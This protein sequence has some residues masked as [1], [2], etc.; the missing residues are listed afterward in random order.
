[1]TR[2]PA[3]LA[4]AGALFLAAPASAQSL[5]EAI[6]AAIANS[7][8]LEAA[9]ARQDAA[10]A[11]VRQ[12]QAERNPSASVQGQ[13]GYGRI[14]PRGFFGLTADNVTPRVAQVGAEWPLFTGGRISAA[15]DQARAGQAMAAIGSDAALLDLRLQ[16][17]AAYS[18]ALASRREVESYGAVI[19]MLEEVLR[20]S[21]LM[22]EAGAATSTDV[23][24][25]EARLAEAQAGEAGSKG[26]LA[27]ALARLESLTG[28]PIE[29]D[30]EL[31]APP[32]I[33][34]SSDQAVLLA[35]ADNPR[36]AQARAAADMADAGVRAA[37]ADI[38]PTVG[39]Y[40]EASSVRD[41]FF[42]GYKADGAS[43][44]LRGQWKFYTGGRTG[45][46]I[47]KAEAE[48]RAAAADA[49]VAEQAVTVQ[50]V[51]SYEAVIAA[52][53]ML[54]ATEKRAAA[55]Q[56][57]LRSTQYEVKAGAKP[58]LALLDASREAMQA[59]TARIKAQGDLL[60]AAWTLRAVAGMDPE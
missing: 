30:H 23:S 17:I 36:L 21:K 5:D 19:G 10:D 41:Q 59:Q 43:V 13:I 25:A 29:P 58:Q 38:M 16:V 37:K 57:A 6:A 51:Q 48:G 32:Q 20:Q 28:S 46:K 12:A 9:E 34:A 24:Q 11:A 39:V 4:A 44:G 54:A 56:E 33:P 22:F 52:R 50:A 26:M 14:D 2:K 35:L 40:A 1:M 8:V 7:P 27:A 3:F 55:T 15:I 42:P 60:L 31:P 18:Q 47:D 49:R 53:A 45:S